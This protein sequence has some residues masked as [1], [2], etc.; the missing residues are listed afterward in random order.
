MSSNPK[1]EER[2]VVRSYDLDEHGEVSARSILG[3]LQEVAGLD[4][5][6][7]GASVDE[8]GED[9][10]AWMLNRL[11]VKV[12]APFPG[13]GEVRVTTWPTGFERV[14]ATRDF[15]IF[16]DA[17]RLIAAASSV[18]VMVDLIRRRAVRM[19]EAMRA[20]P[21]WPRSE[22]IELT[23]RN[24]DPPGREDSYRELHVRRSDQ[25]LL[26]H[27]NN[28]RLAELALEGIPL[29]FAR[30]HR[31]ADLELHFR[32]EALVGDQLRSVAQATGDVAFTHRLVRTADDTAV[33][34]A[35][36]GWRPA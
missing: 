16:D 34:D 21:S 23:G 36:S 5:A 31:L 13:D 29:D 7:A 25:D 1:L 22:H 18:W 15:E 9:G 8:L 19:P 10:L 12:V 28:I 17:G 24:L 27:A 4:S 32:A 2:F 3:Y 14:V 11:R 30:T 6:R 33:L 26:G 20:R 35:A